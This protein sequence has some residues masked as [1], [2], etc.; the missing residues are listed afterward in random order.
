MG[1]REE[2]PQKIKRI[3]AEA[4]DYENDPRWKNYW[5]NIYIPPDRAARSDVVLHYKRKFY[6][7]YIVSSI[8]LLQSRVVIFI[9]YIMFFAPSLPQ[10]SVFILV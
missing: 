1:E 2:D 7:K 8:S 3:A 10:N 9:L 5:E 4:Y 6:Q